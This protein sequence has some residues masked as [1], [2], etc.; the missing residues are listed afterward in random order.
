M[1]DEPAAHGG[2][3]L[4]EAWLTVSFGGYPQDP[5]SFPMPHLLP[6]APSLLLSL[7]VSVLKLTPGLGHSCGQGSTEPCWLPLKAV[8]LDAALFWAGH[9]AT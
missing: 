3:G 4:R 1:S 7:G 6:F 8:L 5:A 9:S 2:P